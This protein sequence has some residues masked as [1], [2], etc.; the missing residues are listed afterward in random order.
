MSYEA[1]VGRIRVFPHPNADRLQLGMVYGSQVIVGKETQTGDL[2]IFF[3]TDG[4]LSQRFAEAND[5]VA[6]KCPTTGEA[7]GGFFAP[8]RRVRAM[9]LRGERSEGFWV[10][11]SYL[12]YLGLPVD[13]LK[14]GDRFTEVAGN[15]ICNKYVTPQTAKAQKGSTPKN[16][17]RAISAF[18]KHCDTKQFRTDAGRIQ[19]GDLVTITEKLHGTSGRYGYVPGESKKL[20]WFQRLVLGTKRR[21]LV[22]YSRVVGSRNVILDEGPDPYYGKGFRHEVG[23]KVLPF[24]RQGEVVYGEIVGYAGMSPIMPSVST[25]KL[26]KQFAQLWGD[27][28]TYKYGQAQGTNEFYVYRITQ[29]NPVG[30]VVELGW[31]QTRRRADELGLRHVPQLEQ[32]IFED[33]EDL[34]EVVCELTEGGS[35][36]DYSHIREGVVVRVDTRR[37]ETF[38]LKEKSFEF[39]VLEGIVKDTDGYVDM[40]ESS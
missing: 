26:G 33:V 9:R 24:L 31:A 12:D 27:E 25:A 11:L 4:Q 37:G 29:V 20:N 28:F 40:E 16:P 1:I 39:K 18:A 21:T 19:Y 22:E 34:A 14:E 10:P 30:D 13:F 36:L 7:A 5:L 17:R 35:T 38:F 6:R 15:P 8:N 23:E 2:G 32:M 3:G